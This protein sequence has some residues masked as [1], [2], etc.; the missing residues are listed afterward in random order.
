MYVLLPDPGRALTGIYGVFSP[1]A[2][3]EWLGQLREA[4]VHVVV[5]RFKIEFETELKAPLT[6]LGMGVAFDP[7]RADFSGMLPRAYLAKH[8]AF[9]S[10]AWQKAFVEVNEEGTEAAAAT[11]LKFGVTSLPPPPIEFVVDRPFLVVLRDDRSGVPLFIGQ[12]VDPK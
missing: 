3:R 12:V 7:Q 9:I 11:G 10:R 5:P 2:M 4:N 8:N 1:P 6:A